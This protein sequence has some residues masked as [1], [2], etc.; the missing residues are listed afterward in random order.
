[1]EDAARDSIAELARSGGYYD[2]V[3]RSG[4]ELDRLKRW[5]RI[6]AREVPE[7]P[8]PGQAP[9]ILPPFPG[10]D[11]RPWRDAAGVPAA[12]QLEQQLAA[13]QRDLARLQSAELLDYSAD[14]V[15]RGQWRAHPVFF[16][17]ERVDRLFWPDLAMDE[18]ARAVESLDGQASALPLADV[19][20][21]A[22]EP[23][24]KLSAHCSWDGFRMRLH[25]GL[26][27]P[28]GC[29]MRV[30]SQSRVWQQG[31]VLVFH[32]SFEHETW[33][34]GLQRRVVLIV[35]CWHPGLTRP[36]REALLALTRKV[37]VRKL[38]AS[39]RLP[40]AMLSTLFA[41]FDETAADDP[42]TGR[43]WS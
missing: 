1:M 16:A 14:I 30:G 6:L 13:V 36:E 39:M 28:G 35:D 22:H 43:F 4:P 34:V 18:T 42:W 24:T 27:V 12:A 2:S 5:L 41:R 23:G 38:L 40:E 3:M 9:V 19:L 26:E 7:P 32:D 15:T 21:S 29:G 37:E 33:N 10:L 17:G 11:E 8:H 25:L 31:R 20:F